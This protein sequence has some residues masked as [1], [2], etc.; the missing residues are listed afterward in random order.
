VNVGPTGGKLGSMQLKSDGL[1]IG[2]LFQTYSNTYLATDPGAKVG[3]GTDNPQGTL[4]VNGD[5]L[6]DSGIVLGGVKK[7]S[8]PSEG[9]YVDYSLSKDTAVGSSCKVSGFTVKGSAGDW[10]ACYNGSDFFFLPP[11]GGCRR[12]NADAFAEAFVC[13]Q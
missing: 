2:G 7:T 5:I 6:A 11:G 3:I 10:G 9:C 13:C 8:W 12:W 4:D 1:A